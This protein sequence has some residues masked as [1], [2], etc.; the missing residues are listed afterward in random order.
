MENKCLLDAPFCKKNCGRCG[1]NPEE[2][3]YRKWL[4][5]KK[6]LTLNRKGLKG[7]VIVREEG[8]VKMMKSYDVYREGATLELVAVIPATSLEQAKVK[9]R[10]MGYDKYCR[11]EES[12][13]D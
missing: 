3:A 1:W 9:A 2:A 12:E 7:L 13:E 11:V 5:S 8:K 10:L 6:G 4:F